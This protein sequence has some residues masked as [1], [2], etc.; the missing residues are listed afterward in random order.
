MMM[1]QQ[2]KNRMSKFILGMCLLASTFSWCQLSDYGYQRNIEPVTDNWHRMI[3]PEEMYGKV[4]PN[5][6]DVRIYGVTTS[7]DTIETPYLIYKKEAQLKSVS[8]GFEVINR[9][10]TDLG[11][12]FTLQLEAART[13]NKILLKFED[14]NFDWRIHLEG[15][16]DQQEWFSILED[17]R[18]LSIKNTT[19]DY[20]FTDLVFPQANYKFFRVFIPADA[21]PVLKSAEILKN[22]NQSG[23][24]RDYEIT[25]QR[26][27]DSKKDKST[28]ID[29]DLEHLVPVERLKIK[30]ATDFDYFRNIQIQYLADSAMTEKGMKYFYRTITQNT[31][32]SLDNNEFSFKSILAKKLRILISNND[33][34]PLEISSVNVS[35]AQEEIIA[36][37]TTPADYKLVYGN[38]EAPR[39]IY[40]L[41]KFV[42]DDI[43]EWTVLSLGE[44]RVITREEEVKVTNWWEKPWV[45]YSLMGLIIFILG[46]FTYQMLRASKDQ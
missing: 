7:N 1:P 21:Q 41:D 31:L 2:K 5:L 44:E 18:I 17:Y 36:R 8:Y 32:S 9:T 46:G 19:S 29:I 6:D 11:Y 24:Y 23:D 12:Y 30:V 25:S 16:Q 40:D 28:Q 34:Q 10:K 27:T 43:T 13:I 37:F 26:I 3:I 38:K 14:D 22:E 39:P 35:G 45:L 20:R 15:S 33:N 4:K 42:K